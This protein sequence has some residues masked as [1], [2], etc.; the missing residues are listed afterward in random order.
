MAIL[1]HN[2]YPSSIVGPFDYF[3]YPIV[4]GRLELT[5]GVIMVD[6]DL[7]GLH[8]YEPYAALYMEH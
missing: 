2:I 7:D 5:G 3:D 1:Q 6:D 4:N 8:D